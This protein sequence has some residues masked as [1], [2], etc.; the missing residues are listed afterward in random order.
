MTDR[1][2]RLKEVV[3]LTSL[4]R[5]KLYTLIA[6]GGFPRQI[7]AG[8]K[9]PRWLESE[10]QAWQEERKAARDAEAAEKGQKTA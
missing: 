2:L 4:S 3:A 9:S 8:S 6:E 1:M 7:S 10:I 5:S